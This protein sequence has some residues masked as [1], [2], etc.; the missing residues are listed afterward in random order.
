MNEALL[1]LTAVLFRA[2]YR[3]E[4]DLHTVRGVHIAVPKG[5]VVHVADTLTSLAWQIARET[6][7]DDDRPVQGR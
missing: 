4:Y 6:G 1:D 2:L 7:R 5:T 3:E